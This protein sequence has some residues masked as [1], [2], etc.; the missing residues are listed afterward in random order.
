MADL[1]PRSRDVTD[2]LERAAA[3]GMLRAVGMGDDDFAKPQVGIASSWN[4][5]TPCNLSLQR[6]AQA[7]KQGVHAGG[8]FPMEFGTISVSDGISMGHE[9]M[10]YSLVSREVIADSVETVMQ[11]ERLDGAL[12]LAGCDKSLPGML[13]AAARLDVA[14]VFLYAGSILPGTVDGREVTII[15]AFEAV[16]AC[17]R[18][19]ISREEVDKIER[20]ICPGEGACGGMYTANTMACAAEAL[21]MSLPGSASPPSVDRRRDRFARESGEAVVGL[22]AAGLTARDILT[23]EAFENAIAVVMALGGSTNAVLHLLAIAHEAEVELT[24]DD[25]TRIGDRVPH[26]ADVKP[27]GRHVMTAVDRV[28][29]VPV[30]MKALLDAGLLHGDCVTVTGKTLAENLAELAPPELD[31]EVLRRLADP[32][33]PT[34]GIT[35]LHGSLAPEGAVVKSAGFDSSRFEGRARVFDGE[36]AA[37]D[38]LGTLEPGDVV[39][40][41][42]EGPR[43]G[44][45]MREMLAVTGAIKGAGLGKDVLLLTDG[46]F[47]GGT[48]GLCIGHVA[49]EAAHGGPIAFVRDGDPIV[50]DMETRTLDVLVDPAEL[51]RRREGWTAPPAPRRTGVLAKYSALVGSAAQG[52][53][54]S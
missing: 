8:G 16:G 3:R 46:R 40:I 5:I 15:D 26:L 28:G 14:S 29:G 2:G 50:L 32:I 39:V 4:E 42:Y 31:G 33:H 7:G 9:G 13:M 21:G 1:K 52:A 24:L 35:I 34:G 51:D 54:C 37:M 38:A 19:L 6:L 18:G 44:P 43:G 17:A 53:V 48:T 45:G 27:F 47:S 20:A 36:K 25:F 30:V 22:L 49:P 23:R 41:R 11:A 12:L 10:H